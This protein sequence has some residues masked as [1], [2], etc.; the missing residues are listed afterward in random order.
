ML[1]SPIY[2]TLPYP[3]STN[4]M[5]LRMRNGG[6]SLTPEAVLYRQSVRA[7]LNGQE[8]LD[9]PV[10]VRVDVYRPRRHGDLDNVLKSL[11]D[12]LSSGPDG[13][14]L[15]HDD[16]QVTHLI[17]RRYDDRAQP[18][19]ELIVSPVDRCGCTLGDTLDRVDTALGFKVSTLGAEMGTMTTWDTAELLIEQEYRALLGGE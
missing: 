9:G 4:H 13:S 10:C 11:L 7:R 6:V 17:A 16:R 18:R 2:L 19:V 14:G 12:S 15:Y 1:P 8:P 5:Y 3:P